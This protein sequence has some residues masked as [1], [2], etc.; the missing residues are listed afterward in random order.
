MA[1]R[2][3]R[4]PPGLFFEPWRPYKTVEWELGFRTPP[5]PEADAQ[6]R[7][8]WK[9]ARDRAEAEAPLAVFGSGM[10]EPGVASHPIDGSPVP[11]S[12]DGVLFL[13]RPVM[14]QGGLIDPAPIAGRV[15]D[16][17]NFC[18][19]V[20]LSGLPPLRQLLNELSEARARAEE[21]EA[22]SASEARA[23]DDDGDI[24]RS[25]RRAINLLFPL[26]PGPN[27]DHETEMNHDGQTRGPGA[28]GVLPRPRASD[29]EDREAPGEVAALPAQGGA[30]PARPVRRRGGRDRPAR[31]APWEQ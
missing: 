13:V 2:F 17:V 22:G 1:G 19:G 15:I 3:A 29:R 7:L 11:T 9:A 4:L 25:A 28:D 26:K 6:A 21:A 30:L 31:K 24:D 5:G 10:W 27:H 16:A 20:D 18:A 23:E 12:G 8:D 14:S